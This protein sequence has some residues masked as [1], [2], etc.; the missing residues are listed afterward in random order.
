MDGDLARNLCSRLIQSTQKSDS[1]P[2]SLSAD[3]ASKLGDVAK[4]IIRR[5]TEGIRSFWGPRATELNDLCKIILSAEQFDKKGQKKADMAQAILEAISAAEQH[6]TAEQQGAASPPNKRQKISPAEE[7]FLEQQLI[8]FRKTN[9]TSSLSPWSR[10]LEPEA[11]SSPGRKTLSWN[12]PLLA[13]RR[14]T[15]L[16][17]SAE[18]LRD[19]EKQVKEISKW[20][21]ISFGEGNLLTERAKELPNFFQELAKQTEPFP[22]SMP[23]KVVVNAYKIM[24]NDRA[25][26]LRM[27]TAKLQLSQRAAAVKSLR[28][29]TFASTPDVSTRSQLDD[30][31]SS[32]RSLFKVTAPVAPGALNERAAATFEDITG[33][34][35]VLNNSR[36][37]LEDCCFLVAAHEKRK[38]NLVGS[39]GMRIQRPVPPA[40]LQ[41]ISKRMAPV[42]SQL[43]SVASLFPGSSR[44]A[45]EQR[46][47]VAVV[48]DEIFDNAN[49]V[50]VERINRGSA[51]TRKQRLAEGKA[52]SEQQ[53]QESMKRESRALSRIAVLS[54]LI[55]CGVDSLA[56]LQVSTETPHFAKE[57]MAMSGMDLA[58]ATSAAK[59]VLSAA[60]TQKQFKKD[61]EKRKSQAAAIARKKAA[62]NK[63]L[64]YRYSAE[65]GRNR[66][67]GRG[68]SKG[69]G[70]GRGKQ[71][72][73]RGKRS[74]SCHRCGSKDHFVK[75]CPQPP[76]GGDSG[77]S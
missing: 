60:V 58:A 38:T 39:L 51:T 23:A 11:G 49:V 27:E 35:V 48:Q 32:V 64:D 74:R 25:K 53:R 31:E 73:R 47:A 62:E 56:K 66:S 28:S 20:S 43:E 40:A 45:I 52:M 44:E 34:S 50:A 68:R 6:A 57:I 9:A 54:R 67:R 30:S 22:P 24:L 14:G 70:K 33:R 29:V 13:D 1:G 18:L 19:L 37:H 4:E 69:R 75:D 71:R 10:Y 46:K 72:S 21:E 8:Q 55:A 5:D 16:A 65:N 76:D 15:Y 26:E 63:N 12:C 7:E 36:S 77:K 41:I 42:G 2:V 59:A 3:D 17:G 61:E